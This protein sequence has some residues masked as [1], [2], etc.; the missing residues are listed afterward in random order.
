MDVLFRN[1]NKKPTKRYLN[2]EYIQLYFSEID[3]SCKSLRINMISVL[4]KS[5]FTVFTHSLLPHFCDNDEENKSRT[6]HSYTS[7]QKVKHK[8][9]GREYYERSLQK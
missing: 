2:D 4:K 5:N 9:S 3:L 7:K 6:L 1:L 8:R